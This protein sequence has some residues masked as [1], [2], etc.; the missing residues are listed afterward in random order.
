MLDNSAKRFVA[1]LSRDLTSFVE[2]NLKEI[3]GTIIDDLKKNIKSLS[4]IN[5]DLLD[6]KDKLLKIKSQFEIASS[7]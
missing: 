6:K 5:N 1:E 7:R 3:Y 2:E 4:N